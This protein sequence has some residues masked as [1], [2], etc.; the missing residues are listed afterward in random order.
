MAK[1]TILKNNYIL[2]SSLMFF[3][4]L[5]FFQYPF[6]NYDLG[7]LTSY[8]NNFNALNEISFWSSF[9]GDSFMQASPFNPLK[10]NI[11]TWALFLLSKIFSKAFVFSFTPIIFTTLSFFFSL[12]IFE[13]YKLKKSWSILLAF[14]GMTSIS[15]MPLFN[16]LAAI[17][18]LN[19][20]LQS[21]DGVYFDLLTS[22]SSSFVLVSFLGLLFLTMKSQL[23]TANYKSF[24][25]AF[26]AASVFVHPTIF[27]F[28]YAFIF[29]INLIELRRARLNKKSIKI[30]KFLII[31]ILPLVFAIPYIFYNL[32][33]FG[34]SPAQGNIILSNELL[35]FLKAIFLYFIVPFC[36]ML[37][38]NS[39]HK[40]DPYE[41]LVRFWPILLIALIEIFLR[42]FYLLS[43]LPI[44]DEVILNR[45]A[46]YFLHF[47]YY[48]PFLS[49]I[50]REFT[51]L[52]DLHAQQ[53][54]ALNKIRTFSNY[55]FVKLGNLIVFCMIIIVTTTTYFSINHEPYRAVDDR[56]KLLDVNLKE[57]FSNESLKNKNIQFI[58]M[59]EKI[60]TTFLFPSKTTSNIF[61]QQG[62]SSESPEL[63]FLLDL[64]QQDIIQPISRD[65]LSVLDH[66]FDQNSFD[67]Y[68]RNLAL[69]LW[70]K[71]NNTYYELAD[72]NLNRKDFSREIETFFLENYLISQKTTSFLENSSNT[73][74]I[75]VGEYLI[76]LSK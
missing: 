46:V 64:Y 32:V 2:L 15:S 37:F 3:F 58:S 34:S 55:L 14:F 40:V 71:Y 33:F 6:F 50:T 76:T 24:L 16:T 26:W 56:A 29:S 68:S 25:P 42:A 17:F 61:I 57:I 31:H 49:V 39:L 47:F 41:S 21:S 70:L 19:F 73:M 74:T 27:I 65:K 4:Y 30:N 28:G 38:A 43:F 67:N 48:L 51:Y 69:A 18:T 1:M 35:Y 7:V 52:P 63:D 44:N 10:L 12:K 72:I 13:L 45:V 9:Y 59:D 22:F 20:D 23:Y 5:C 66:S 75:K 60:I 54:T 8:V 36:L 62:S 53:N 11:I